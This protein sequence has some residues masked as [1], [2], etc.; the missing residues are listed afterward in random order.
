MHEFVKQQQQKGTNLF[1]KA[2]NDKHKIQVP[3][4]LQGLE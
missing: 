1:L 3:G 2:K 4:F